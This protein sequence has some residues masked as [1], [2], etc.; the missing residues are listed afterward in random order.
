MRKTGSQERTNTLSLLLLCIIALLLGCNEGGGGGGTGGGGTGTYLLYGASVHIVDPANPASPIQVE[1]GDIND[2][3]TLIVLGS[4]NPSTKS[5]T[6][7]HTQT[8]FYIVD[9]GTGKGAVKMVSMVKGSGTPT[10]QQVSNIT[11]AC[12]IEASD[13]DMVNKKMW[14]FISTAGSDGNCNTFDDGLKL[15]HSGMGS[16]D[17]PMDMTGKSLITSFSGGLSNLA[18]S[19]FLIMDGGSIEKCDTNLSNCST[20]KSGVNYVFRVEANPNNGNEYICVDNKLHVF[21]GSNLNPVGSIDCSNQNKY[22]SDGTALYW[23]DSSGN[24]Y[25]LNHGETTLS[26]IYNGGDANALAAATTNYIIIYSRS[27]SSFK[28]IPKR[29]GSPVIISSAASEIAFAQGDTFYFDEVDTTPDTWK[30]CTW[31]EGSS[32][33]Y[34]N[35]S[36]Y[37]AG[38]I[39]QRNGTID[40][41]TLN[42]FTFMPIYRLLRVDGATS[43]GGGTLKA[44]NPADN[45]ETDLGSVHDEGIMLGFGIGEHNLLALY[46]ISSGNFDVYYVNLLAQ[47]SLTAVATDPNKNE[48]PLLFPFL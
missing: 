37:W 32:N 13:I 8:F 6:D 38:V 29:G 15:I 10:P 11:D 21:D 16:S 3:S 30:A 43:T 28:A 9:D 23:I 35:S 34:C 12:E 42:L 14:M 26:Q 40:P 20:L 18:I 7:L 5:Y 33:L 27:Y 41:N 48:I 44:I 46:I 45:S 47:N 36:S 31:K 2:A 25:R 19:G 24:I 4:Y 17:S 1:S 22:A 39:V